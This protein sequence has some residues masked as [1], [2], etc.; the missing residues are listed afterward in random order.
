MAGSTGWLE[1]KPEPRDHLS[2]I[3]SDTPAP[4][5][6]QKACTDFV[7]RSRWW[8]RVEILTALIKE[9]FWKIS[10][11]LF[12]NVIIKEKN[13]KA[14]LLS[15]SEI[16]IQEGEVFDLKNAIFLMCGHFFISSLWLFKDRKYGSIP[17]PVF[18]SLIHQHDLH[19][20][21][22]FSSSTVFSWWCCLPLLPK[23]CTI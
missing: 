5:V 13:S 9:P 7:E 10:Y 15:I 14:I 22:V 23:K 12:S 4:V 1:W 16:Y 18:F 6:S 20:I 11:Q 21:S 19:H 3:G 8:V 17:V 2:W